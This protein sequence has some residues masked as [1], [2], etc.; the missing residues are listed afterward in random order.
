MGVPVG[1][2]Q[3]AMVKPPRVYRRMGRE[4][5]QYLAC[6]TMLLCGKILEGNM[7]YH[8]HT[9]HLLLP[10]ISNILR[11]RVLADLE[12]RI[13]SVSE[14]LKMGREKAKDY[15]NNVDTDRDKWIKFLYGVDWHDPLHYDLVVNLDQ[16]GI[17]NAATALCTM[18]ELPDF[19]LPPASKIA[20]RNLYLGSKAHFTLTADPRTS[21]A[22]IKVIAND[23]IVQVNYLP[24]QSEVAPYVEEVLSGIDGIK[25]VHTTVAQTSLLYIQ[26]KFDP[27]SS[28]FKYIA[29]VARKWDAVI[30]LMKMVNIEGQTGEDELSR[31]IQQEPRKPQATSNKYNGGIEDDEVVESH[32]DSDTARYLDKLQNIGCAG[33]N[34]IFFGN[35][36]TL[37]QSL[38]RRTNYSMIILGNLFL[39]KQESVRKRQKAEMRSLFSD[40]LDIPVVDAEDLQEQFKFGSKQVFKLIAALTAAAIIFTG[41]FTFQVPIINFLTGEAYKGY[42]VLAILLIV[43][44]TPAFAF[45][46][47]TFAKQVLK[48]LRLE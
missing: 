5:D 32:L 42:R 25:E 31:G 7:V 38:Q 17:D 47:G 3:M 12:F 44:L 9:G 21:H 37:L 43:A 6:M 33:G 34:S 29:N 40:N 13:K 2:L 8:G 35:F 36:E 39:S 18:A 15:I 16:T 27:E 28:H 10:G 20:I 11:I 46:Y 4:R 41:V 22:D 19:K 48:I 45:S 30:E 14:R 23:G 26:E 1:K 24:Q